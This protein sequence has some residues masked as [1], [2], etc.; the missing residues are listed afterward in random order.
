MD[1]IAQIVGAVLILVAFTAGQRGSM[2]PHSLVYLLLNLIGSLVLAVV[3]LV[4]FDLGFL[5]LEA[6]W[7]LV[8][9]WGL[10]QLTTGRRPGT[11]H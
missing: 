6:V 4:E 9:A 2:S 11:A 3:A 5:L 10:W 7:A 1:Q 8:S